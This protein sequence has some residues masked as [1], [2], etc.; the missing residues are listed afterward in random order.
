[1]IF[2]TSLESISIIGINGVDQAFVDLLDSNLKLRIK[3]TQEETL[4]ISN[5]EKIRKLGREIE[6]YERYISYLKENLVLREDEIKR[7]KAEYKS[8]QNEL[9]K[10]RSHLE[11]KE[12]A[13]VAQDSWI[14]QLEETVE[15]L[16]TNIKTLLSKNNTIGNDLDSKMACAVNPDPI[17]RIINNYLPTIADRVQQIRQYT[18]RRVP[19]PANT[20]ENRYDEIKCL[21]A[22]IWQDANLLLN[23]TFD[24]ETL[25]QNLTN[26]TAEHDQYQNLL[27]D[28][29]GR[30]NDLRRQLN[31]VRAQVLRVD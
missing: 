7:L 11:L 2:C 6:V 12:K 15:K 8:I 22:L 14:I 20:L 18:E 10:C 28:E 17:H 4:N 21:L 31:D 24:L 19:L 26:I 13:L 29:N 9:V 27:N 3:L 16:R 23:T 25:R 1:L 5:T 30:V